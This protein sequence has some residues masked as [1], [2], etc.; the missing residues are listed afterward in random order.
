MYDYRH[1]LE[2]GDFVKVKYLN[3]EKSV[4]YLTINMMYNMY[5]GEALS[6]MCNIAQVD[7]NHETRNRNMCFVVPQV[8]THGSKSFTYIGI[9]LWN[10]LPCTIRET[11]S[12]EDFTSKCKKQLFNQMKSEA[13]SVF[14]V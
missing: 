4:E 12:K 9:K 7:H 14:T 2:C 5:H 11:N 10:D 1:H 8:K 6:Y 3:V 13:K